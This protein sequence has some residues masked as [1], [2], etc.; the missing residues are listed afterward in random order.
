MGDRDVQRVLAELQAAGRRDRQRRRGLVTTLSGLVAAALV[1][2]ACGWGV[3]S[4]RPERLSP[5]RRNPALA[6][7][8]AAQ[9]EASRERMR[10][11]VSGIGLGL[12]V[13]ALFF[14]AWRLRRYLAV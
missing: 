14:L 3:M 11:Y 1:L 5:E 9:A 6:Y 10:L 2:G 8:P 12:D 13:F 7:D 4:V